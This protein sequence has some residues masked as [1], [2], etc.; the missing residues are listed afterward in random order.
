M[1]LTRT[2]ATALAPIALPVA[3][4][5]GCAPGSVGGSAIPAAARQVSS[6]EIASA[7]VAAKK[8]ADWLQF[9]YDGGHSGFNPL[10]RTIDAQNV[11]N[12]QV[13]WNDQTII[14]PGGIVAGSKDLYVDDMG[15]SNAGVYAV[16]PST[17]SQKWYANVDLN[18]NWG[19]VTHAVA[20]IA[21]NVVVTPCSNGS[22]S[23]FLTGLCGLNATT[24]KMLW[25]TYCTEYQ[26]TPCEGLVNGTSPAYANKLIYFQST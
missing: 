10:E 3:L 14:Q 23:K 8:V 19:S 6:P 25:T 26:G 7:P 12:L 11:S 22:S 13:S 2:L 5:A 24:G 20:A 4:L 1:R 17:G 16:D 18:G 15:Q 9:G 21:G